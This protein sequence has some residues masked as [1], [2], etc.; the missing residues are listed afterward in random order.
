MSDNSKKN[1]NV[2]L[3]SA[4]LHRFQCEYS[5]EFFFVSVLIFLL[6]YQCQ[7]KL[8]VRRGDIYTIYTVITTTKQHF[9]KQLQNSILENNSIIFLSFFLGKKSE[10]QSTIFNVKFARR[11]DLRS[12]DDFILFCLLFSFIGN[13]YNCMHVSIKRLF[14]MLL[15]ITVEMFNCR[16]N[17]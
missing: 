11:N 4:F 12:N 2:F 7:S 3:F 1:L 6:V 14:E 10:F 8:K 15:Q 13:V 17:I 16:R 9:R 5:L